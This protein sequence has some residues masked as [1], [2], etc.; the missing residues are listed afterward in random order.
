MCLMAVAVANGQTTTAPSSTTY[1]QKASD[2]YNKTVDVYTDADAAGNHFVVGGEFDNSGVGGNLVP[3]MNEYFFGLGECYAG[4]TCISASFDPT[5]ATSGGWYFLN[6]ILGPTALDPSPNWGT[7]PNAGYDLTNAT[8]LQFWARGSVGGEQV[9]FFAFGVGYN[10]SPPPPYPD[11]SAEVSLGTATLTQQWT[12]YVIPLTALWNQLPPALPVTGPP[13]VLGGFGW[14]ATA[15]NNPNL[16]TFYLDNIQYVDSKTSNPRFLVSYEMA[17]AIYSNP[18]DAQD[19]NAAFVY[20]NSLAL[21]ALMAAGDSSRP[22]TIADA[23]LYAQANDRYFT[24]NRLRN[25]YQG[26]DLMQPPGWIPDN[27][28]QYCDALAPIMALPASFIPTSGLCSSVRLPGWFNSTR[29]TWNEEVYMVS[30]NTKA[31]AWAMLALLDYFEGTQQLEYL[32]GA[33]K[34]GYWLIQNTSDTRGS[35]GFTAGY[36][37]WETGAP[38]A[39]SVS[40]PSNVFANGQCQRLYKSTDDNISLYAA[41][42]RINVDETN[43]V[44][45]CQ[46]INPITG[47]CSCVGPDPTQPPI[48]DPRLNPSQPANFWSN[49]ANQAKAFV[50]SMWNGNPQSGGYFWPGTEEDGVTQNQSFVAT[51]TQAWA[52]EAFGADAASY[53]NALNYVQQNAWNA[54]LGPQAGYGFMPPSQDSLCGGNPWFEG[55]S[56][57]ALAYLLTGNIPQWQSILYLEHSG[58]QLGSGAMPVTAGDPTFCVNTGVTLIDGQ[59]LL[60]WNRPAVGATAWLSMAENGVNPFNSQLYSPTPQLSLSAPGFNFGQQNVN[61]TSSMTLTVTDSGAAPLNMAG[62]SITGDTEFTMQSTCA[63][64]ST[65]TPANPAIGMA[66]GAC[67]ITVTF[68]PTTVGGKS[69]NISVVDNAVG[70]PQVV[71]VTGTS[72]DFSISVDPGS[73]PTQTVSAGQTATYTMD[74]TPLGFFNATVV[75][76]C[77]VTPSGNGAPTCTVSPNGIKLNGLN[78]TEVALKVWTT[79]GS[80]S[81][82]GG[83]RQGSRPKGDFRFSWPGARLWLLILLSTVGAGWVASRRTGWALR[84]KLIMALVIATAIVMISCGGASMAPPQNPPTPPDTYTVTVSGANLNLTHQSTVTLIVQ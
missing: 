53:L 14:Q 83:S 60:Y 70:S 49:A 63:A 7:V 27:E 10:Q 59:P 31:M 43:A 17:S 72:Q 80:S 68:S 35:G 54:T 38:A 4:V 61:S 69:A 2:R 21:I 40:C 77:A 71:P 23:L 55:T 19:V 66:A 5:K 51:E 62:V 6:G 34:L 76:T 84:L 18:F 22:K 46:Q 74:V 13:Y 33:Q 73:Q 48:C 65:L 57:I 64:G 11:A 45:N 28:M 1:L 26:G 79:G 75:L 3:P 20:D 16:I 78:Y 67:S 9:E 12:Q 52:L 56:Q 25:S 15:A 39:I 24:D 37:G 58:D 82:V 50:L 41:F 44:F 36:E 47:T 30:S 8:A 32:W 81:L 42:S 29:T